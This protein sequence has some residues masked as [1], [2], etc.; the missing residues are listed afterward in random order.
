MR[1]W[2]KPPNRQFT[3]Y[4]FRVFFALCL[5]GSLNGLVQQVHQHPPT[6]ENFGATLLTALIMCGVVAMMTAFAVWMARRRDGQAS[7]RS[8]L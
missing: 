1:F 2:V 7:G 6:R 3:V 5:I 4:A 8:G